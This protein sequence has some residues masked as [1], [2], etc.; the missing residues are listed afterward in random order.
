[1]SNLINISINS[2]AISYLS[3]WP[4]LKHAIASLSFPSFIF[5]QHCSLFTVCP[6]YC[7]SQKG[8]GNCSMFASSYIISKLQ[9][10]ILKLLYE[11]FSKFK[12]NPNAMTIS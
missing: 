9:F 6:C 11:T 5:S 7:S 8:Q 10:I 12:N 3:T 4:Q 1:M 2:L